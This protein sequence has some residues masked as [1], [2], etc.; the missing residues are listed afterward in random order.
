[1]NKTTTLAYFI[2]KCNSQSQQNNT[3]GNFLQMTN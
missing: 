3:H 2:R 1:M